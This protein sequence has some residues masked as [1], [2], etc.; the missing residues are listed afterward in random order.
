MKRKNLTSLKF[1]A[2]VLI[3]I[4]SV[5]IFEIVF[6]YDFTEYGVLP[7]KLNG[8]IGILFSPLIHSDVN[9]LLNNSLPVII[10]C[11]LI[12]N[13]Y[14]QIAKKYSYIFTL[15]QAYGFGVLEENP[16]T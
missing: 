16:F 2:I 13:F 1:S 9:H 14:S 7:R 11:L 4:W 12:F 15:F 10:L 6:D 5:K 8:L 3:I